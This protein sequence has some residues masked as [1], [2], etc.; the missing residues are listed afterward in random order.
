MLGSAAAGSAPAAPAAPRSRANRARTQTA[1][2]EHQQT[3]APTFA[4]EHR[5]S[6]RL[7][8]RHRCTRGSA[9]ILVRERLL[10][11]PCNPEKGEKEE[12]E[13]LT[14]IMYSHAILPPEI[15]RILWKPSHQALAFPRRADARREG[16][17]LLSPSS[18]PAWAPVPG[19]PARPTAPR[20]GCA[21]PAPV[22]APPCAHCTAAGH[23][24]GQVQP[25]SSGSVRRR[26]KT[27]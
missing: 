20:H 23:P 6:A 18:T 27:W 26:R 8:P 17:D 4:S 15:L 10:L 11:S 2:P 16:C 12:T 24:L 19:L 9:G 1:A 5:R 3:P 22:P 25:R 14:Q 7:L 21:P 13:F